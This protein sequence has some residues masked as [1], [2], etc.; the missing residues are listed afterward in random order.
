MESKEVQDAQRIIS[1]M[2]KS[3]D[4]AIKKIL[5]EAFTTS[6]DKQE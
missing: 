2:L 1:A 5:Q 6:G 4:P 3:D